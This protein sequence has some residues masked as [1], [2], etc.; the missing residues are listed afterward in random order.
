MLRRLTA[1]FSRIALLP[2]QVSRPLLARIKS[3]CEICRFLWRNPTLNARSGVR[4]GPGCSLGERVF[5]DDQVQLIESAVGR[6]TAIGTGTVLRRA[7]VGAFCSL[8]P[9]VRAGL[10]IHPTHLLSSSPVF[11]SPGHPAHQRIFV[12]ER[13]FEESAP[14]VIGN[15]VW[16]GSRA[17]ILDGIVIGDGAVVAA[18]AVVVKDVEPY[19]IV[20]GVPAKPIRK[21]FSEEQIRRLLEIKWWNRPESWLREHGASFADVDTFLARVETT[22]GGDTSR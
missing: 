22:R 4:I 17:M 6:Y 11:Y 12:S 1:V 13:L 7:R 15:D 2:V 3:E 16:I 14:V 19:T 9:E 5:L 18:G 21:R 10:G 8:A 20:G